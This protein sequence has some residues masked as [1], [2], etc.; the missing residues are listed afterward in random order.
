MM[1][2]SNDS[3]DCLPYVRS[4]IATLVRMRAASRSMRMW[5]F[6]RAAYKWRNE[7]VGDAVADVTRLGALAGIAVGN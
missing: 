3:S 1:I 7:R 5:S 4:S 2:A 6:I